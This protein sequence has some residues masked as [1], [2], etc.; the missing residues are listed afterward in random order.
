MKT[1]FKDKG[2]KDWL[3]NHRFLHSRLKDT[4]PNEYEQR[5]AYNKEVE[6]MG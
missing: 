4:N 1:G 3:K 5:L 2:Y 6:K